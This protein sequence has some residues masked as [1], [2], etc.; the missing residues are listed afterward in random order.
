M[1]QLLRIQP[2]TTI[3]HDCHFK[4]MFLISLLLISQEYSIIL[5]KEG[6]HATEDLWPSC[7]IIL[8]H[9]IV[10]SIAHELLVSQH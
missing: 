6:P 7:G 10:G 2:S 4:T 3:T 5:H 1:T 9:V 8:H